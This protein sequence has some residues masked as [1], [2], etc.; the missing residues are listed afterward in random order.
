MQIKFKEFFYIPNLLSISRIIF[1]WP[2]VLLIKHPVTSSHWVLY[3]VA[4]VLASTDFLDG[5]LSRKLNQVTDLGK[6]LD[7]L[8]DKIGM[9]AVFIALIIYRHF[10]L[11]VIVFLIYRDVMIILGGWILMGKIGEPIPAKFWGKVNTTVIAVAGLLF[12][13]DAPRIVVQILIGI[14]Y[15]TIFISGISYALLGQRILFKNKL[16]ITGFWIILIIITGWVGY[17][18][19]NYPFF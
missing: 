11:P 17:L 1:V 18:I 12:L 10:P 14:S 16:Q 9:A 5:Y 4:L 6:V 7:P 8:A 19:R 2:F 3:S 13:F 15:F